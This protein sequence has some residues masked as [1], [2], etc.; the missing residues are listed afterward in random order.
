MK[1]IYVYKATF[2]NGKCYIGIT[3]NFE[4]R[5]SQHKHNAR[6]GLKYYFYQAIRKYGFESIVWEVLFE[7]ENLT[8]A[9]YTEVRLIE[10][11]QPNYNILKGKTS[12]LTNEQL[13]EI[14]RDGQNGR[15]HSEET[16]QKISETQI[17]QN[18]KKPKEDNR[19]RYTTFLSNFRDG[20]LN[21]KTIENLNILKSIYEDGMSLLELVS[22]SGISKTT[23][24]RYQ[25]CWMLDYSQ[26]PYKYIPKMRVFRNKN[27]RWHITSR[28][29]LRMVN[30]VYK[31][32]ETDISNMTNKV[33]AKTIGVGLSSVKKY[34]MTAKDIILEE[35]F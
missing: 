15:R 22:K 27:I 4:K 11:C 17:S 31:I 32:L 5:K 28:A 30:S 26:I 16:R 13:R 8:D 14:L 29:R 35:G 25:R 19:R 7:Y 3:N 34:I 6:K 12:K 9:E 18:K 33:V 2:Q 10:E 20:K 21:K 24:L 1:K 23:I